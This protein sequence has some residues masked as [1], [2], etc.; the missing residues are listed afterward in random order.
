MHGTSQEETLYRLESRFP[1]V[2]LSELSEI[3]ERLQASLTSRQHWLLGTRRQPQFSAH[4]A[5]SGD[6]EEQER[7]NAA[8]PTPNPEEQI[9]D[10][11]QQA[12]LRHRLA[13]L[14]VKERLLLQLRF[15]QELSLNE[16]ARLCGLEDAQRVHRALAAVLKKLRQA[17]K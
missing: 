12:L 14:S 5:V 17:M 7:I 1:D 8:D 6:E 3:E 2:G 4:V 16:I 9:T 11:E 15:E 13:S 10:Q